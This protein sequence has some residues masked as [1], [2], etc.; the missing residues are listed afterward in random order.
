MVDLELKIAALISS[1]SYFQFKSAQCIESALE[2]I[3][4]NFSRRKRAGFIQ[5]Q[6]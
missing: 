6:G 3:I 2:K 1:S 5:R 4:P